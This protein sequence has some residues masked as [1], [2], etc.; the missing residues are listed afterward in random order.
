MAAVLLAVLWQSG[1]ANKAAEQFKEGDIVV[2]QNTG[3]TLGTVL[4]V[5][6]HATSSGV[7][8]PAVLIKD[9]AGN[10]IWFYIDKMSDYKVKE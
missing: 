9:S 1:C 2:N 5:G 6:T 10:E 8:V 7:Q 3:R 4:K